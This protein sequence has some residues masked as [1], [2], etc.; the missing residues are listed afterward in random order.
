MVSLL[1]RD[2]QGAARSYRDYQVSLVRALGGA[3]AD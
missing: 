2:P 1:R 3:V